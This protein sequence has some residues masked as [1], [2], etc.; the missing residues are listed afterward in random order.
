MVSSTK[1]IQAA[2]EALL[3]SLGYKQEFRRIF[4]PIEVFGIGFSIIGLV[5]SMGSV[6]V[7]SIP[8]GGPAAMVWGWATCTVFLTIIALAFAELGSAAPTSGG[9]YYWTYMFSS[10]KWRCF[11][12][13]IVGYS[14]TIGNIGSV[15]SVDWG[16]AV[17]IMAAASIGSG[18]TFSPTV[19]QTFAV[20]ALLLC[21]HVL[22]CSLNSAVIARLQVP[23]I[24]LNVL[25]CL[26]IIIGVPA[27]T[28]KEFR[29]S[30]A[31]AFS[32]YENLSGW[33][34]GFAFI[35][36][37]LSPLWSVAGAFDATVHISEEA[38]NANVA[39]PYAIVLGITSSA[40]LGWGVN[41]ALAFCM[42]TDLQS[43][44]GSPI[45]QPMAVILFNS[46]GQQ[47][48]LAIWA[49]IVVVQFSMGTSMLTTTS[50]QIFAF[51]RDGGLP[52]SRWLYHVSNRS[53][54]P[55][56]C[57]WFA[58]FVSLLL[59]LLAFAGAN[60]IGAIFSLV[61]IA[62]YFA[63]SIPISARFLGGKGLKPGPFSL[64]RFSFPVALT[65]VTWM[66]FIIVVFL[67]PLTPRPTG[68][69][70][71]YTVLVFG[72]TLAISIFYF[73]F[74]IYGGIYWFNGPVSTITD[75]NTLKQGEL[76]N[77]LQGEYEST[78]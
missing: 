57:V 12:S 69:N 68:A 75:D 1:I 23:Y 25:L 27:A 74:P 76:P 63:Y 28:P 50:R 22:I 17:Q 62:Q 70:M 59:G 10:P 66:V 78:Q 45:Q 48:T 19:G 11:L 42:G 20:Y 40:L 58:A 46:F 4:S 44:L 77:H 60:A 7:Y 41:V 55:V 64:G 29:N 49:F 15:A 14:N 72:G 32:N 5:P 65:A 54:S 3:A 30:A 31:F 2:D 8:N 6:L 24:I 71:N 53:H 35:L 33:P 9:L 16:C 18:L 34:N 61:V 21:C 47:G 73:Y 13:W 39:I 43:I 38:T 36:S 51:S 37:F 26:A 56:R 67:F 52:F